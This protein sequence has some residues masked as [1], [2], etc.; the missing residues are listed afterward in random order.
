MAFTAA[1]AI[2]AAAVDVVRE[3]P[4]SL[5]L[6]RQDHYRYDN[7]E[8]TPYR[9][10]ADIPRLLFRNFPEI[11]SDTVYNNKDYTLVIR[12][13]FAKSYRSFRPRE[14]TPLTKHHVG[15][16]MVRWTDGNNPCDTA[17]RLLSV[18]EV[19]SIVAAISLRDSIGITDNSK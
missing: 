6:L 4:D 16:S 3:V 18:A 13:V 7:G 19:D 10:P 11:Y 15:N 9:P 14:I 5:T 12:C 2:T 8:W 17:A 1:A